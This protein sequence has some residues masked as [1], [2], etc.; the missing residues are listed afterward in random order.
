MRG[1]YGPEDIRY[2]RKGNVVYAILLGWPGENKAVTM[3]MFGRDG[4]AQDVKVKSVSMLGSDEKIKWERN[5][6]GLVITTPSRKVDD[7]AVVFKFDTS[8]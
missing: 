3:T 4:K 2:T 8:D 5:D 1:A 6:S 7:L